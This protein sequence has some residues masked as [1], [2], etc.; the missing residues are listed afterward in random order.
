MF[1]N[2][3]SNLQLFFLVQLPSMCTLTTH[4]EVIQLLAVFPNS[5][6]P[7][8]RQSLPIFLPTCDAICRRSCV[9]TYLGEKCDVFILVRKY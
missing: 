2:N 9:K 8:T 6:K 3:L 7:H 4:E 1:L 5:R